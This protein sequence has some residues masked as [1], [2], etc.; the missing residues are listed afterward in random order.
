MQKYDKI[1]GYKIYDQVL[2]LQKSVAFLC[3]E[4][5]ENEIKN[6]IYQ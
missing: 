2:K 5:S 1:I 6:K 3:R 4:E